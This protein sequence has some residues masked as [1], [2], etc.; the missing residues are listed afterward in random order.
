MG[1]TVYQYD[2]TKFREGV[3]VSGYWVPRTGRSTGILQQ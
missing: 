2:N 3:H 1:I